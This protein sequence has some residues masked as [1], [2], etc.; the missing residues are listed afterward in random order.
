[1][2]S[3]PTPRIHGQDE[4]LHSLNVFDPMLPRKIELLFSPVILFSSASNDM[5]SKALMPPK[6]LG[7]SRD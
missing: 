6:L 4:N 3:N 7:C 2:G 5:L 1:M